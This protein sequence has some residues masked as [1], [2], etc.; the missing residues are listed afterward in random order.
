MFQT[1]Y[2][3][4]LL[5]RCLNENQPIRRELYKGKKGRFQRFAKNVAEIYKQ[6]FWGVISLWVKWVTGKAFETYKSKWEPEIC[7]DKSAK[8]LYNQLGLAFAG[9]PSPKEKDCL[10]T[11]DFQVIYHILQES[12]PLKNGV[13]LMTPKHSCVIQVNHPL[14]WRVQWFLGVI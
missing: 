7:R 8:H 1:L 14:H 2:G 4:A 11:I 5:V 12:W 9:K 13:I 6:Q 3:R 10:P